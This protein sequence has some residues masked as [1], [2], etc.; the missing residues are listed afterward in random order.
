MAALKKEE[1]VSWKRVAATNV[2]DGR[3]YENDNQFNNPATYTINPV[4]SYLA[5]NAEFASIPKPNQLPKLIPNVASLINE[6]L[7]QGYN[8]GQREH[9]ITQTTAFTDILKQHFT[10]FDMNKSGTQFVTFR[11]NINKIMAAPYFHSKPY[12]DAFA[13]DIYKKKNIIYLDIVDKSSIL[14]TDNSTSNHND[15]HKNNLKPEWWGTRF[16]NICRQFPEQQSDKEKREWIILIQS[17]LNHHKLLMAAEIDCVNDRKEKIEI[18]TQ[19]YIVPKQNNPYS[20]HQSQ[21]YNSRVS[22]SRY[23]PYKKKNIGRA[24]RRNS[25]HMTG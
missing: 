12:Y 18:K 11:N 19:K 20:K 7:N 21:R 23:H 9:L 4:G 17:E 16:E 25:S 2:L 1:C 13:I 5:L 22:H 6:D 3:Q 10:D 15:D 8:G 14:N 24:K